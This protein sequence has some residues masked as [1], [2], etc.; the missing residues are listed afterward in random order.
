MCIRDR[1]YIIV[2]NP[3]MLA[4]PFNIM[5]QAE[6]AA[7]VQNGVFFATC[8]ISF[9]GTFLMA[10]YAKVPFAQAPG[11]GLNAFFAYTVVLTTDKRGLRRPAEADKRQGAS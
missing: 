3:T 4:D 2:V 10:M 5:G 7:Q 11:M 9:F 1:A 6:Y 8:L